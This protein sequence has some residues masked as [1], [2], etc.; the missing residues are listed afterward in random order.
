MLGS[1]VCQ[2]VQSKRQ[3]E[4]EGLLAFSEGSC[5]SR[6]TVA[7]AIQGSERENVRSRLAE[8][9]AAAAVPAEEHHHHSLRLALHHPVLPRVCLLTT[10]SISRCS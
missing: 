7:R 9:L 10:P 8:L 2:A 3:K 4:K 5:A 6:D 1:F